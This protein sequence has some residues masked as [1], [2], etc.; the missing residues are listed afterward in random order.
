MAIFSLDSDL[1]TIVKVLKQPKY[2]S[3]FIVQSPGLERIFQTTLW[4]GGSE[5]FTIFLGEEVKDE[6]VF[7]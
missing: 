3:L 1:Y 6:K 5:H 2:Y 7:F 4:V